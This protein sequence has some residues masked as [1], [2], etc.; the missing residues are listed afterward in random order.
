MADYATEGGHWYAKDGTPAYTVIG[1][2]GKERPT[3]LRDARKLKLL[4]SVT[5][6]MGLAA[7]PGLTNWIIDQHILACLTLPN[8]DGEA[9]ADYIKRLKEDAKAQSEKARENG[10]RIHA[11]IEQGFSGDIPPEGVPY[12]QSALKTIEQDCGDCEWFPEKSFAAHGYGGKIDLHNDAYLIDVKT[13]EKDLSNIKTW[14][15]HAMQLAAYANGIGKPGLQCGILYINV[16][17]ST[18]K[19]LWLHIEEINKGW[20]CFCALKDYWYA[21]NDMGGA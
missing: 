2:D 10:T 19:L 14:D 15:E 20:R 18:S 17:D 8:I 16:N 7:K 13:T 11:W 3:T 6:I 4:P 12:F 5:S 9:E 21:K 1:K